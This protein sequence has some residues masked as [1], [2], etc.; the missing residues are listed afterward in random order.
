MRIEIVRG[1][2]DRIHS[3]RL[4]AGFLTRWNDIQNRIL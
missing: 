4:V 3:P 1:G 2:A